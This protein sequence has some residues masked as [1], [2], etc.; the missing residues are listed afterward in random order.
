MEEQTKM[1]S[2]DMSRGG[3]RVEWYLKGDR[4]RERNLGGRLNA[5]G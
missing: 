4:I 3:R 5:E 2:S 1:S